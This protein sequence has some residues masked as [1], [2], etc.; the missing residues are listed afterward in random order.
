MTPKKPK[1]DDGKLL[2]VAAPKTPKKDDHAKAAGTMFVKT[3]KK[4]GPPRKADGYDFAAE[5]V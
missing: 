4:K 5:L 3:T 2:A 1:K